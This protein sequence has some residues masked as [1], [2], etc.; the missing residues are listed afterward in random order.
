MD[1]KKDLKKIKP[2]GEVKIGD[3][4]YHSPYAGGDW[5][6][7]VGY[8]KWL[9]NLNSL[10]R[11]KYA[12]LLTDGWEDTTIEELDNYYF[13]VTGDDPSTLYNYNGDPCGLVVYDEPR[14]FGQYHHSETF[15]LQAQIEVGQDLD[16]IGNTYFV[17]LDNYIAY[18]DDLG[19][20]DTKLRDGDKAELYCMVAK[21]TDR[22]AAFNYANYIELS[23]ENKDL[24]SGVRIEDT[25]G[26]IYDRRL[27]EKITYEEGQYAG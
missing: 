21:F 14:A 2:F 8:V 27:T 24:P 19:G 10:L 22:V 17:S 7:Q 12:Y 13:I 18:T 25:T 15:E 26:E 11:S 3:P 5:E 6:D 20:V 4:V 9:G 1:I 23:I 16:D